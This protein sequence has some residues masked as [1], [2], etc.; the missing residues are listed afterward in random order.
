MS[1]ATLPQTC[2]QSMR[3]TAQWARVKV[4]KSL[5]EAETYETSVANPSRNVMKGLE[6]SH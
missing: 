5:K 6:S 3:G 4:E 2:E 1:G